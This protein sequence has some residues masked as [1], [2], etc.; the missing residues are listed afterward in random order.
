MQIYGDELGTAER[1]NRKLAL[2]SELGFTN[3]QQMAVLLP[4]LASLLGLKLHARRVRQVDR[5]AIDLWTCL[6]LL[7]AANEMES[8]DDA[9][10]NSIR[11]QVA[12]E[13]ADDGP[14]MQVASFGVTEAEAERRRTRIRGLARAV[15]QRE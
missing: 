15:S 13:F 8:F 12:I 9:E 3:F 5:D 7:A 1:A 14:V 2:T 11:G 10:F 6:E 4:D